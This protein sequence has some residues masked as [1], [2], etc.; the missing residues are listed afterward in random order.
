MV[1]TI[2]EIVRSPHTGEDRNHYCGSCYITV[3]P[4]LST[5]ETDAT[6]VLAAAQ[7]A[8]KSVSGKPGQANVRKRPSFWNAYENLPS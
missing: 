7:G 3:P 2:I 4:V 8:S 6:A 5:F 1:N